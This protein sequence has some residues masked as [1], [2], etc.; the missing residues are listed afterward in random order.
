MEAQRR[1]N[2]LKPLKLVFS[3]SKGSKTTTPT[4]SMPCTHVLSCSAMFNDLLWRGLCKE[5]S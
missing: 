2:N 1:T 3:F 4:K 5:E